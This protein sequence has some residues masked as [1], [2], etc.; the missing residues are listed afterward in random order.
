M[1]H[2][3]LCR[4]SLHIA[5][6]TCDACTP[7][8]RMNKAVSVMVSSNLPVLAG[9]GG[10]R[11]QRATKEWNRQDTRRKLAV[12]VPAMERE[13]QSRFGEEAQES[14]VRRSLGPT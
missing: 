5:S 14:F 9:P 6:L 4:I 11:N 10:K 7:P 8:E 3:L 1:S 12:L 13:T 2:F